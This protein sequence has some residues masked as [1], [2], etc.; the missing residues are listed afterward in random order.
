MIAPP[1][2]NG[3][4]VNRKIAFGALARHVFSLDAGIGWFAL[5]EAGCEPRSAWRDQEVGRLRGSATANTVQL[6]DPLLF[7]VAGGYDARSGTDQSV[8]PHRLHF[9]ILAYTD[10]VQIVVRLGADAHAS[11]AISPGVDAYA[12]GTRLVKLFERWTPPLVLQ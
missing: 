7:L 4:A 6:I 1:M 10:V 2:V 5:E 12:L 8:N 3:R 9:V 11:V